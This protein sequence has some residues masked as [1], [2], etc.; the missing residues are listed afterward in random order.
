[1][2]NRYFIYAQLINMFTIVKINPTK[3][4]VTA[5]KVNP[6]FSTSSLSQSLLSANRNIASGKPI[7]TISINIWTSVFMMS[8][9]PY[10]AV[11]SRLV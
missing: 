4:N 2:S 10:S 8:I 3:K 6:I 9:A 7:A 11:E 1:M 5:V